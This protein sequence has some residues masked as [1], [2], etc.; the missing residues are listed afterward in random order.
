[1][2]EI[3]CT[4][5]GKVQGVGYRDFVDT[6][7]KDKG[8]VG[9]IKNTPKGTVEVLVQGTPDQLKDCIE[10][11]HEGSILAKVEGVAVDWRTPKKLFDAFKV[12][13]S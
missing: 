6:Y 7:A 13:S 12:L 9:W 10:I 5:S 11:L 3:M 8:L 4:V 1:M 2:L